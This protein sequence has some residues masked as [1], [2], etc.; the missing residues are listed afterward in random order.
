MYMVSALTVHYVRYQ[1][2]DEA[3][4][5]MTDHPP[6]HVEATKLSRLDFTLIAA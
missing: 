6:S 4:K 3:V 2:E 1:W 5:K